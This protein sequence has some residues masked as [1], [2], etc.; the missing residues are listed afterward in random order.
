MKIIKVI[1]FIGIALS[2]QSQ[3]KFSGSINGNVKDRL[4]K[5]PLPFVNILIRDTKL[6]ASSD[7]AGKFNIQFV[8]TGNHTLIISLVGY[9]QIVKTDIVVTTGNSAILSL[10]MDEDILQGSEVIVSG[11]L[12]EKRS[13]DVSSMHTL[14]PE[15]IRRAAGGA[16]DV[17]RVIQSLPGI[18]YGLDLQNDLIVRGGSP[19]ENLTI[20]D[21]YEIQN[22]NHFGV[23]GS[24]GG[25][26]GMVDVHY[27]D[28]VTMSTGGFTSKYGD[29]LSSVMNIRLRDGNKDNYQGQVTI[30][31]AGAGL[32]L[33]GPG[34]FGKDSWIFSYRKSFLN[35]IYKA[36]RLSVIPVYSDILF[37][38][39]L[40]LS[41]KNKLSFIGIGGHDSVYFSSKEDES[42]FYGFRLDSKK[43]ILGTSLTTLIGN[44]GYTVLSFS[45]N[46]NIQDQDRIL[47]T[48]KTYDNIFRNF[49]TETEYVIRFDFV[50]KISSSTNLMSGV[51]SRNTNYDFWS[52]S[53]SVS[54]FYSYRNY[55]TTSTI[56]N[57]KKYGAYLQ[58]T[59][60]LTPVISTTIGI[61]GDYF[62]EQN[63]KE[64]ISPRASIS[65]KLDDFSTLSLSVGKYYQWLSLTWLSTI[66]LN[67]TLKPLEADHFIL[68]YEK[69]LAEDTR[70]MIEL[71]GKFYRNYSVSESLKT[72]IMVDAGAGYDINI[73]GPLLDGGKG[74]ATGVDIFLQKKYKNGIYGLISYSFNKSLY[75]A[76][77]GDFRPGAWDSRHSL[78][79]SGGFTY[80]D[81][82]DFSLK[83]RYSS[84][85]PFTPFDEQKSKLNNF[86]IPQ[87]DKINQGRYPDYHRIDIRYDKKYYFEGLT[88]ITF[89]EI[90]NILDRDNI[91]QY[92]WDD[93]KN[94]KA[95]LYQ[96][97]MLPAGGVR[98]EF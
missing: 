39:D 70:L 56:F 45:K 23:F 57:A 86:G 42:G 1:I 11:S 7:E 94:E 34:V 85:R 14:A 22:I 13:E 62:S 12:F 60:Q 49:T 15:E 79:I 29:K 54:P 31:N 25:G 92:R 65:Y 26:V 53:K 18:S 50:Y 43:Y 10:E 71:F 68:G 77:E 38:Y 24:T 36:V 5:Q 19:T 9:K 74:S 82:T 37:K 8:P 58:L 64:T 59:E 69:L 95:I 76:I 41:D 21:N 6:G 48:I 67:K 28:D 84:G 91:F 98:I 89:L 63:K 27:I 78:T 97:A 80:D 40:P 93:K 20:I 32:A 81:Q 73:A 33:E 52:Y 75:K 30:G 96:M 66:E 90:E 83:Y 61:R 3:E 55:D 35:L 17:A 46:Q 72:Y 44:D 88:I 87:L 2:L 47:D 4:T 16:E 51:L